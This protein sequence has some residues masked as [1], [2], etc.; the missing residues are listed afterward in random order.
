M[1]KIIVL[2]HAEAEQPGR[3]ARAIHREHVQYDC[4]RSWEGQP[5]PA[6]VDEVDALVV[7]G[8]PMSVYETGRY[9]F[10]ADEITL[11]QSAISAGKPVL[12][13]CLGSQLMAAALGARVYPNV[14]KEIGWFDIRFSNEAAGDALLRGL[15]ASLK[16][17][18]WHGDTF[19]LPEG[20]VRLASSDV[21]PNQAFRFGRNAYALQ[22]H[23]EV[24]GESLEAL[25]RAFP[26]DL[27]G[28]P[29]SADDIRSLAA[30][31]LAALNEAGDSF[32]SRW[33]R[34]AVAGGAS[35]AL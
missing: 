28:Q 21:T 23:M 4:I 10:L 25:L 31:H 11:V 33:V 6:N 13:V 19:D 18:H 2:Q 9:P 32:F 1:P 8:G 3:I 5:V 26:D 15:P 27:E 16:A 29:Q 12:G 14:R 17:F 7:M 24:D 30:T 20:A 22:F 34:V 35:P